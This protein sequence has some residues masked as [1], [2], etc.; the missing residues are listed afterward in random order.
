RLLMIQN[1]NEK[2]RVVLYDVNMGQSTVLLEN[3]DSKFTRLQWSDSGNA[4]IF[5]DEQQSGNVLY[6]WSPKRN[7][8]ILN[9][10][11]V[12]LLE[13]GYQIGSPT[14]LFKPFI[15]KDGSR[16]L[17]YREKQN[18]KAESETSVEVWDT[19]SPWI[20]PRMQYYKETKLKNLLTAWYPDTGLLV[21]IETQHTPASALDIDHDYALVY[22]PL[23]Y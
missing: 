14:A 16:V 9:N 8:Q 3:A 13:E 15:S 2:E 20:Y 4:A 1:L 19:Q 5:M 21:P 10:N 7:L 17:F 11:A 18:N 23:D 6:H 22:N 12:T